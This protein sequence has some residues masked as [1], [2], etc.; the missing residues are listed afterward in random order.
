MGPR[1]RD[2]PVPNPEV[3]I[4]RTRRSGFRLRAPASLTPA[5][6]LK[7]SP[8]G[9][10]V[11]HAIV[12][13]RLGRRRHKI[14]GHVAKSSVAFPFW[15]GSAEIPIPQSHLEMINLRRYEL[16]RTFLPKSSLPTTP[17]QHP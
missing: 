9:P 6:R 16:S 2:L 1:S 10:M 13:G 11:L 14:K 3:K 8:A 4:L 12:C 15:G 17:N 7:L 5:K